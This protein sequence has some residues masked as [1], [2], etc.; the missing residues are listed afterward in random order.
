MHIDPTTTTKSNKP[1]KGKANITHRRL[2]L[3]TVAWN[4]LKK[5]L[6]EHLKNQPKQGE[7]KRIA[8]ALGIN[9]SQVHRFTCPKCEHDQEPTFSIGFA[10][11]IYLAR[12]KLQ[13]VYEIPKPKKPKHKKKVATLQQLKPDLSPFQ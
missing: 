3:R 11:A 9:A 5:A 13:P 6:Q 12:E 2:Y 4:P 1:R 8:R 10:L 7:A